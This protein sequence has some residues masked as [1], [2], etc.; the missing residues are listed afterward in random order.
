MKKQNTKEEEVSFNVTALF[1]F[2]ELKLKDDLLWRIKLVV[3]FIL[4]Q[5]FREYKAIL[6]LN[7]GP[8]EMRIRDLE[9]KKEA[10][11]SEATLFPDQ[12]EKQTKNCDLAIKDILLEME[13]AQKNTPVMEFDAIVEQLTYKDGSTSLVMIITPDVVPMI[14]ENRSILDNYKLELIR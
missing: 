10:I 12:K 1:E 4:P 7:T 11:A 9:N 2:K 8:F 3:N 5:T 13:E 14:N 6:S